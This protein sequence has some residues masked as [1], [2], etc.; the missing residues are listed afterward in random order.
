MAKDYD[1][2]IYDAGGRVEK[3]SEKKPNKDLKYSGKNPE[4]YQKYFI[5]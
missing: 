1:Y 2:P 4:S 3:K 5:L